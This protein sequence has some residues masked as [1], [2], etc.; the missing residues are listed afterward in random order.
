MSSTKSRRHV[1][2]YH[3]VPLNANRVW[4]CAL[5]NCNHYM[6]DHM[7]SMV[8][9]KMSICHSCDEQFVLDSDAMKQT[10]PFCID[11]RNGIS[12]DA[13]LP[14]SSAME[15]YLKGRIQ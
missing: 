14:I 4:A 5:P 8:P 2:K 1:H 6:P 9:G 15:E 7:S 3:Q 13:S 10:R 11:C 12:S